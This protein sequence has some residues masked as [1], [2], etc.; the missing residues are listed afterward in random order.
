[1]LKMLE[2][3]P[4]RTID[5]VLSHALLSMPKPLESIKNEELDQISSKTAENKGESVIHH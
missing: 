2:I 4:V 1:M 3:V 5:E